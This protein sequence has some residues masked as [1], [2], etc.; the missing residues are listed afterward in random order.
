M[1]ITPVR[2]RL[3]RAPGAPHATTAAPHGPNQGMG[4]GAGRGGGMELLLRRRRHRIRRARGAAAAAAKAS[5][6]VA[7]EERVHGAGGCVQA[8]PHARPGPASAPRDARLLPARPPH[9]WAGGWAGG[10]W[11]PLPLPPPPCTPTHP[12]HPPRPAGKTY[13]TCFLRSG[14]PPS[15]RCARSYDR[16]RYSQSAAGCGL[17]YSHDDWSATSLLPS[18]SAVVTQLR[19]PLDRVLSSYQFATEV[20]SRPSPATP[21]LVEGTAVP[22]PETRISDDDGKAV[23]AA[24][25]A[26]AAAGA[27]GAGAADTG[28]GGGAAAANDSAGAAANGTA[29]GGAPQQ[30]SPAAGALLVGTMNVWPWSYL[31]PWM[32]KDIDK[33]V[34]GAWVCAAWWGCRCRAPREGSR[35][36][37]LLDAPPPTHTYTRVRTITRAHTHTHTRTHAEG[38]A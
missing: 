9:R 26:A 19:R 17:V 11:V 36:P 15:R 37:P 7:A 6:L 12:T 34:G 25:A 21:P 29:G 32:R 13:A 16:L 1:G 31:V 4:A 14:V 10:A 30:R 38:G 35:A 18:G 3:S 27:G 24:D 8:R 5:R 28:G 23:A 33:R 20:A 2:S 22:N